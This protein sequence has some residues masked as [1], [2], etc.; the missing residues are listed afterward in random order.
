ME[1]ILAKP[2][3]EGKVLGAVEFGDTTDQL[4]EPAPIPPAGSNEQA[5]L[6]KR[7]DLLQAD[8]GGTDYN[9][10]FGA[11]ADA[12]PGA[13]ARIFMTDG[14]HNVGEY[15]DLHRGGP[16]TFVIGLGIGRKGVDGERL[17]RIASE[18][19]GRYFPNTQDETLGPVLDA[20][21]S[22]L[23]CDL[24][25][26][27]YVEPTI[28]DDETTT[29]DTNLDQDAYS[30]DVDVSWDDPSDGF[31]IDE[32]DVVDDNTGDDGS[33]EAARAHSSAKKVVKISAR[34]I[35]RA[36]VQQGKG[37]KRGPVHVGGLTISGARGTG[38]LALR[39]RGL[40]GA[41]KIRVKVRARKVRG[42]ARLST[43]VSQSR[44]RR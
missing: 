22:R 17:Q 4:I 5:P 32:V 18:T 30:A 44:R 33:A 42:N 8:N 13:N 11:L 27:H 20:I 38:Y 40:H 10:A 25:L 24:S 35:K 37:I 9:A 16:P 34:R 28:Q 36:L 12:D 23:N 26:D 43:H 3:N 2:R 39:V 1:L 19:S 14:A 6:L 31:E 29:S 41:N 15:R 7:L 21:D